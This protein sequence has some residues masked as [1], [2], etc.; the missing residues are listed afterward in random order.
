MARVTVETDR[1]IAE[2][3]RELFDDRVGFVKHIIG[4]NPKPNQ[5]QLLEDFDK[6]NFICIRSGINTGKSA[7]E[8]WLI[9]HYMAT[10]PESKTLCTSPSKDQLYN[11]LWSELN[12]WH[13]RMHPLFRDMFIW[14]K[15]H[16]VHKDHPHWFAT[17]R[18]A[19]K[20]NPG[21]LAGIHARYVMRIIDEAPSVFDGAFEYI[22][23]ATGTEETKELMCGNPTHLTG[24]F[25][26]A[27]HASSSAYHL[28]HWNCLDNL[29]SKGGMVPDRVVERIAKKYGTESNM[30]KIRVLGDFPDRDGD[31]YIP[32][33]WVQDALQRD[34]PDQRDY[35]KVFGCDIAR[36]GSDDTVIAIRQGDMFHPYHVLKNKSTM[37]TAGY[38][39]KLAN[40]QKPVALF[41]DVIGIGA[42]V[43][44]RLEELG[45]P[46]IPVNVAESPALDDRRYHRLRDELWGNMRDWLESRRG[47]LWDNADNEL[48]GQLTTPRYQ[49]LNSSGKVRIETK[50]EM[51]K[52]LGADGASPN[53]A[54]A[55]NLT[56]AQPV[57]EYRKEVDEFFTHQHDEGAFAFALDDEAGY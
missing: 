30:Y 34:I 20:D 21:S 47:R 3:V 16:F 29:E 39:A 46:V 19:T 25:Y 55:H 45:Y 9:L 26:D 12:M 56:F 4:A 41:I 14:Q 38:I 11:V 32:F 48:L 50:D 54:D 13:K 10:R 2:I 17:A 27:F 49:I 52:R 1:R 15:T 24:T 5:L 43:F 35:G 36:Y 22:E 28:I 6:H 37:E 33:E 44:D 8:S 57:S 7:S 53:I 42:G 23:G 51:K 31:S 18:T 40:E